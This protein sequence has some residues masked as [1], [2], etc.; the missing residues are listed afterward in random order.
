MTPEQER[1]EREDYWNWLR[2]SIGKKVPSRSE[3]SLMEEAWLAACAHKEAQYVTKIATYEAKIKA[4]EFELSKF[5][6][7]ENARLLGVAND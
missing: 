6:G 3:M 2:G 5:V 7:A 4:L 1:A